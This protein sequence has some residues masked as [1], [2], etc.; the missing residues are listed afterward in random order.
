MSDVAANESCLGHLQVVLLHSSLARSWRRCDLFFAW[1]CHA[2]AM[3]DS[4]WTEWT[5]CMIWLKSKS[6][7]ELLLRNVLESLQSRMPAV[8][9]RLSAHVQIPCRE[10]A[11]T[12]MDL[13]RS[14]EN[15]RPRCKTPQDTLQIF[16]SHSKRPWQRAHDAHRWQRTP[17]HCRWWKG[18]WK[19]SMQRR[20]MT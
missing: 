20:K 13:K 18:S 17:A 16:K 12:I 5:K 1:Q 8:W 3:T 11:Y 10:I 2:P 6:D 15:C 9:T 7:L 4:A 14:K 19:R